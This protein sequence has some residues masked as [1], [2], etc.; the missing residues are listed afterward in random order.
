MRHRF[1]EGNAAVAGFGPVTRPQDMRVW[2]QSGH[3]G[4]LLDDD[5][6]DR[7]AGRV[8]SVTAFPIARFL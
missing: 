4:V 6:I 3:S 7:F 8:D 1:G 2:L 5:G